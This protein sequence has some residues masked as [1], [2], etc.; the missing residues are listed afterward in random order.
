MPI[1]YEI[2]HDAGMIHTLATG[3]LTDEDVYAHKRR[4]LRDPRYR[5]GMQEIADVRGVS[6]LAVTPEGIRHMVA[7]DDRDADRLAG[8]RLAIVAGSDLV[9]GMARMYQQSAEQTAQ[10]IG[11]FR[12][13]DEGRA[14]LSA[15][16]A[17]DT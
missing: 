8:R 11:V 14:W 6:E 9:F 12:T 15:G 2:D 3:T 7:M 10:R 16:S 13:I 4:L 1:S 5:P 17:A